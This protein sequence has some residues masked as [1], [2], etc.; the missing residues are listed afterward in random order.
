MGWLATEKLDSRL[1]ASLRQSATADEGSSF[2]SIR[3]PSLCQVESCSSVRPWGSIFTEYSYGV[4]SARYRVDVKGR[5]NWLNC[6]VKLSLRYR[7][8]QVATS[9]G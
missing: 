1:W 7:D 5:L 3:Y 9:F 2:G 4:F 6:G 8:V